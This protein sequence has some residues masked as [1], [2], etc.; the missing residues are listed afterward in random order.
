MRKSVQ[1]E[2]LRERTVYEQFLGKDGR[3]DV[4]LIRVGSLPRDGFAVSGS[5]RVDLGFNSGCL[6]YGV[7]TPRV[8]QGNYGV[9][10]QLW[11]LTRD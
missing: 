5:H 11:G 7:V 1:K 8:I 3:D 9:D 10:T 2:V 6:I 4:D